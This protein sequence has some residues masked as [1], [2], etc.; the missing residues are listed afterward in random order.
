MIIVAQKFNKCKQKQGKPLD[1][2]NL[3]K[4]TRLRYALSYYIAQKWSIVNEIISRYSCIAPRYPG[5]SAN[6]TG[7]ERQ[8]PVPFLHR[9]HVLRIQDFQGN[10]FVFKIIVLHVPEGDG[11]ANLE[12]FQ[13]AE[14][15]IVIV[16]HHNQ[17]VV[18]GRAQIPA[19][20]D[21][22]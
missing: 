20:G 4:N 3:L 9:L 18:I 19:G 7:E 15:L 5:L 16:R 17:I 14:M 11:I 21:F 2:G 1:F 12:L 8:I 13:S 10:H 22:Q 6:G